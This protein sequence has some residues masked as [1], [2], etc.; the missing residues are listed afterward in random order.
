MLIFVAEE[1]PPSVLMC[2]AEEGI[3]CSCLDVKVVKITS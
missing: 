1:T 2:I 3:R